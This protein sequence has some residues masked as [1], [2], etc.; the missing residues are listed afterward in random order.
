[1]F[2]YQG[3]DNRILSAAEA[4]RQAGFTETYLALLDVL[5]ELGG[6]T[7]H[8]TDVIRESNKIH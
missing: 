6:E 5:K 7:L 3:F 2:K 4:A 1:M 8:L